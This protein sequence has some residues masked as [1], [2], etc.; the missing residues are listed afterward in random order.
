ML[1]ACARVLALVLASALLAAA[2]AAQAKEADPRWVFYTKDK[3]H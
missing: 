2:P 1:S 3:T